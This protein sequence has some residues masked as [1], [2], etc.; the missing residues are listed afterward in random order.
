MIFR[1]L[2]ANHSPED[3]LKLVTQFL[4]MVV[5]RK[6]KLDLELI[7]EIISTVIHNFPNFVDQLEMEDMT[8]IFSIANDLQDVPSIH[9]REATKKH[10]KRH[11]QIIQSQTRSPSSTPII[12]LSFE[13]SI[14]DDVIPFDEFV[15]V[16]VEMNNDILAYVS[17][18][19]SIVPI[20]PVSKSPVVPNVLILPVK[21][22]S[23]PKESV[24][25]LD[26]GVPVY[27]SQNLSYIIKLK[28]VEESHLDVV[29]SE[30]NDVSTEPI[31]EMSPSELETTHPK[32]NHFKV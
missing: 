16:S 28:T 18:S 31:V 12:D 23:N 11:I 30:I 1:L 14:V 27:V 9:A 22:S 2:N 10:V 29:M 19:Q 32:S 15:L 6:L 25:E 21:E 17:M 20:F 3:A 13:N 8:R 26:V 24:S 7:D 4:S 5:Q